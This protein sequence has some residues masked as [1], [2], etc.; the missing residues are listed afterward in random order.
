MY[1]RSLSKLASLRAFSILHDRLQGLRL[2]T[3]T[4]G[5]KKHANFLVAGQ[6][7]IAEWFTAADGQAIKEFQRHFT[8]HSPEIASVRICNAAT[9]GSALLKQVAQK[10]S[11]PFFD[12]PDFC[13]RVKDNYWFDENSGDLGPALVSAERSIQK[14]RRQGVVFEGIIWSQG[15]A[16]AIHLSNE[17]AEVYRNA[18][19][20]VLQRLI[21]R[22]GAQ[23]VYIQELGR[24]DPPTPASVHGVN[25]IRA[26][27]R[28]QAEYDPRIH[29][30]STTFDIPLRDPVH[31]TNAGYKEAAKR[32]AIG[33]A[34]GETSPTVDHGFI[35]PE[36]VIHLQLGLGEG[37]VLKHIA[38]ADA[39]QLFGAGKA[40]P[41]SKIDLSSA[42]EIQITPQSNLDSCELDYAIGTIL[43]EVDPDAFLMVQGAA[44]S[45]PVRP[46]RIAVARSED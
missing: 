28:D 4:L 24:I 12:N 9:G 19:P 18:L 21:W 34:A 16:D 25:C 32:M 10:N 42:G 2:W 11:E 22:S 27:Q 46:F 6:S 45:V 20:K 13:Q 38:T 26:A 40:Q 5:R 15:E 39:F 3:R 14:W 7:N 33:I 44:H 1:D 31:L 43:T 35:D 29:I 8:A 23:A 30:A 36:G 17:I 37:Q 41:I